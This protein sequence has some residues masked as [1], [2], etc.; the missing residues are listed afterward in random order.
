MNPI[1]VFISYAHADKDYLK[2]ITSYVNNR[3]APNINIWTDEE[4][5]SPGNKWD[6]VIKNQLQTSDIILL[7]ISNDFVQ[8][9]YIN[10]VELK[11]ALDREAQKKCIIIPVYTKACNLKDPRLEV[12]NKYQGFPKNNE[13][14]RR[15]L[16]EMDDDI[17]SALTLIQ[18]GIIDAVD[19]INKKRAI[20]SSAPGNKDAKDLNDLSAER[21]IFLAISPMK[22]DNEVRD[23]FFYQAKLRNDYRNWPFSIIPGQIAG[24]TPPMSQIKQHIDQSLYSIHLFS[25]AEDLNEGF[26]REQL[27]YALHKFGD[28]SLGSCVLWLTHEE[29]EKDLDVSLMGFERVVG[30]DY[31]RLFD[32]I[33]TLEKLR[34]DKVRAIENRINAS[35]LKTMMIYDYNTDQNSAFRKSVKTLIENKKICSVRLSTPDS[36]LESLKEDLKKC[37]GAIL[38]YG[39]ADT[40][41]FLYRQNLLY[42]EDLR[43]KAV[44]VCD[45][46][47]DDKMESSVSSNEFIIIRE[48]QGV[49]GIEDF[50]ESLKTGSV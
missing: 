3:I 32:K 4:G 47:I 22:A 34:M 46:R 24:D 40:P 29:L 33:D 13:K 43:S 27:D 1:N 48:D 19:E 10:D 26:A 42:E 36:T 18:N 23:R 6:D 50:L 20:Q 9:L 44:L 38:V 12:I 11:S 17:Y 14:N 21:R 28:R 2:K 30:P 15:F 16:S 8:S 31:E 37:Q 5:I 39:E 41:W 25:A 49:Q 7:L 45:P 35:S